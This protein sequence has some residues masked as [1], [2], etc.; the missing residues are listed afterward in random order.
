MRMAKLADGETFLRPYNNENRRV[1]FPVHLDFQVIETDRSF[2]GVIY[3]HKPC[4]FGKRG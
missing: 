2:V 4:R 1:P 3:G